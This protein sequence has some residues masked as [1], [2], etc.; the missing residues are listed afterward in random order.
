MAG[1]TANDAYSR[2]LVPVR[3]S[4]TIRNTVA[5]AIR[6]AE[7]AAE[8][9]AANPTVHFVYLSRQRAFD[10]DSINNISSADEF[11]E[12]VS[13]WATEDVNDIQS[14]SM[15]ESAGSE[16]LDTA[17]ETI[18]TIETTLLWTDRY[19]FSPTDFAEIT[20]N[21]A[22][23]HNLDRII[24][25]P[26]YQPGG[27][28]P[29]LRSYE[30]ALTQ[31]D[32]TVEKAPVERRTSRS[33]I[34]T[35]ST[36]MKGIATF[37]ICNAFYLLIAGSI[38]PFNLL[39][40]AVTALAASIAF[41]N[42]TFTTSPR[43]TKTGLRVLRMGLFIP[44]LLWEIA[45]ANLAIAYIILHPSLP[46]DPEMQQFRAGVRGAVSVMTLANSITLTPGTL[47]V[48]VD[49]DGLYIHTLTESARSDLSA[50]GLER[51]VRFVFYGRAAARFPAPTER[52]SILSI[53][54]ESESGE[55]STDVISD[56]SSS[57]TP[58][59]AD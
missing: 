57:Q 13:V 15:V 44:Y 56:P 12:R 39:T 34:E 33:R 14:E 58:Q 42:I 23:K 46:I 5:Y 38:T 17:D 1:S 9:T 25:D 55:L 59:E 4:T 30:T 29:M 16:D 11:L 24:V 31:A 26:E 45:K 20:I 36:L 18:I 8:K 6:A 35:P 10:S 27:G 50:G 41:S 54:T 7:S 48:D 52:D 43:L 32:C 49:D 47:T 40:G 19:L 37:V 22:E 53:T 21:Y 28:A 2:L 3:D 51:A